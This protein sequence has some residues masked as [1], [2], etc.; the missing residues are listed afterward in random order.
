MQRCG[1]FGNALLVLDLCLDVAAYQEIALSV[2][3]YI[4]KDS[5]TR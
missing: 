1:S 5:H 2:N 3:L 4:Y